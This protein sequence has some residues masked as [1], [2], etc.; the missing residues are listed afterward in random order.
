[1]ISAYA[2]SRWA[3]LTKG[4]RAVL[5]AAAATRVEDALSEQLGR[6]DAEKLVKLL[7]RAAKLLD[8]KK[9]SAPRR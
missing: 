3:D 6:A 5:E 4:E 9:P 2:R 1:M 8:V 7:S